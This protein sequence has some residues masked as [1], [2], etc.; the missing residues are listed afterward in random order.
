[1]KERLVPRNYQK[2]AAKET[3][4]WL[5]KGKRVCVV[6]PGGIGK[7]L[8]LAMIAA[9]MRRQKLRVLILAQRREIIQQSYRHL[10][11]VGLPDEAF[12]I[13]MADT[14]EEF[15]RPDAPVQIGSKGTLDRRGSPRI[16][17]ALVDEC[18]HV[19]APGYRR[20]VDGAKMQVG[21]TASPVRLGGGGLDEMYD[22]IVTVL[23]PSEAI[24]Q[25]YLSEPRIFT[26]LDKFLPDMKEVRFGN[27]FHLGD[28][29]VALDRSVLI[30][31]I[32]DNHHLHARGRRTIL[33]A[34][35]I[36]HSK[37][38][39]ARFLGAG[40]SAAHVDGDTPS[41]DRDRIIALF[42][43][44]RILILSSCMVFNE[45]LSVP[46]CQ[47]NILARPTRSLA[48]YLQQANRA[49]H[50]GG[51]QRPILL[52]HARNVAYHGFP[53]ADRAWSLEHG[54]E[55]T[56]ENKALR[57]STKVCSNPKC[58]AVNPVGAVRCSNP[59]CR[60]PFPV[61]VVPKETDEILKELT[62]EEALKLKARLLAYAKKVGAP[63]DWVE[64]VLREWLGLRGL[65]SVGL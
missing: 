9:W 15:V 65:A 16:D 27:D 39:V 12:G 47:A 41:D 25:G 11:G 58:N 40:V 60:R 45:G 46:E 3:I 34:T 33:H 64:R 31:N 43:K 8:I 53:H 61:P 2:R 32:V 42:R 56:P 21:F 52:D 30:G 36:A 10:E 37:K 17:A 57:K 18:Q 23:H 54:L 20:I 26:T 29:G 44:G 5:K 14:P 51:K 49:M 22:V 19:L 1:M 63:K 62:R 55:K 59:E 48:L 28:L 35:N 50:Y 24:E 6:G 4:A 38:C 13:L 7:T